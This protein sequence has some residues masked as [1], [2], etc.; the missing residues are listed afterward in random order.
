MSDTYEINGAQVP[1][2]ELIGLA[3]LGHVSARALLEAEAAAEAAPA[4]VRSKSQG[5]TERA[6]G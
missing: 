1:R 3:A 2:P 5:D 6:E 4:R